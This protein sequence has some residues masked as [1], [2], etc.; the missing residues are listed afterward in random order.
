MNKTPRNEEYETCVMCG[1]LTD[2]LKSIPV[3]ARH[4]YVVGV[5]QLCDACQC[6]LE[7]SMGRQSAGRQ[8]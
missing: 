7:R 1:A 5:G 4:N 3:D 2:M 6:A 8:V